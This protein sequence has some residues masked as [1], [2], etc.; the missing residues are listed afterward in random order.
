[1]HLFRYMQP[2]WSR[3]MAGSTHNTIYMPV[4]EKLQILLPPICEQYAIAEA[5]SDVDELLAALEALIAKKRAIKQAAMQQLLTGKMRLPGFVAKW[6]KKKVS[7][8]GP[9]QRGFDLPTSDL[10]P[11]PYPVV[12]SNGVLA[13]HQEAIVKGPG[14]VTGR[15]GT[16]GNVHYVEE[17][18]WPH[19]T[20]LWVTS[21]RGNEPKF[22]YY[23]YTY[24][25]FARFLSGSGVP[26]L[27]RNDVHQ[28]IVECPLTVEQRAITNVLSDMDAEIE[29]LERR[30]EKTG[31][32]K[33][34]M[35][36]QLLTG[37]IRL[38]KPQPMEAGV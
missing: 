3:L 18:F 31:A 14:V 4:F 21:F 35:M 2:E 13:W 10:K 32:I 20:S 25:N 29:A 6:E 26:T 28:H 38:V 33:Q 12:Y 19:N 34:G 24:L 8:V 37:R 5:L 23:L 1:M 22:V 15:S 16:I 7:E 30:R 27:N 9:L 17:D 36:Q 11:G